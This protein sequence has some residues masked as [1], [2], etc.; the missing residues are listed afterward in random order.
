MKH[1]GARLSARDGLE[2]SFYHC[3]RTVRLVKA[4]LYAENT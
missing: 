4:C 1:L 2:S 3:G